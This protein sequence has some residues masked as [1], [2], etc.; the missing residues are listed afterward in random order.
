MSCIYLK[1]LG[2]HAYWEDYLFFISISQSEVVIRSCINMKSLN[3]LCA[4][5]CVYLGVKLSRQKAYKSK[6]LLQ[7]TMG[8]HSFFNVQV[9]NSKVYALNYIIFIF[10]KP[11]LISFNEKELERV[12]KIYDC[13][14][15]RS[16]FYWW[17][18]R[19]INRDARFWL[20]TSSII[21]FIVI[22][23]YIVISFSFLL[24]E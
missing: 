21:N 6:L 14:S 18:V 12:S 1:I 23:L 15:H 9:V 22:V 16:K 13:F 10:Y 5:N 7:D 24:Q 17:E 11:S 4:G 20:E 2:P 8:K 19:E 3:L